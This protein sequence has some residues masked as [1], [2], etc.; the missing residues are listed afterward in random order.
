MSPTDSKVYIS[1]ACSSNISYVQHHLDQLLKIKR[2]TIASNVFSFINKILVTNSTD[3]DYYNAKLTFLFNNGAIRCDDVILSCLQKHKVTTIDRFNVFIDSRYFYEL[4]ESCPAKLSV[5]LKDDR[6][7]ILATQSASFLLLPI[8]QAASKDFIEESLASFVTPNDIRVQE[9]AN[10]AAIL[11]KEKYQA[12]SFVGY[13][14]HDPEVVMHELDSLYLSLQKEA[15]HYSNPPASFELNFQRVRLPY[16]AILQKR[17]TAW[18][19]P[20]YLLRS[21]KL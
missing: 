6:G 10:S 15:I 14:T 9:L 16:L 11:M 19:L 3:I 21:A 17:L 4:G 13:K 12:H 1:I 7:N 2:G 5:A 20:F 8:E 18:I